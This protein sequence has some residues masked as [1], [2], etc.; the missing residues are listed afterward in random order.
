[1]SAFKAP[2]TP[3]KDLRVSSIQIPAFDR[4]PNTSIQQ[5]P[6]LIYHSA[7][8]PGT[9]ASIIEGHLLTVGVV[10]PQ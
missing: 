1:M 6:L 7:F 9:P 3:L 10:T 8:H 5:K 2:I 4:L